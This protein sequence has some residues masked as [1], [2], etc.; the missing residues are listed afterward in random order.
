MVA[1]TS[2]NLA[3]YLTGV[4][5][6]QGASVSILNGVPTANVSGAHILRGYG[7]SRHLDDQHRRST[8]PR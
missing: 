2:A 5:S 6:A 8:A 1:V 4:L 7:S 3:A